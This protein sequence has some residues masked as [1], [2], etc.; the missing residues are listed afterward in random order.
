MPHEFTHR[1]WQSFRGVGGRHRPPF[2][3]SLHDAS[4]FR[5]ASRPPGSFLGHQTDEALVVTWPSTPDGRLRSP[6]P[7]DGASLRSRATDRNDQ[8]LGGTVLLQKRRT[9]TMTIDRECA[10]NLF[11]GFLSTSFSIEKLGGAVADH[12]G[13]TGFWGTAA[14]INEYV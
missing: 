8:N 5:Q 14:P 10:L 13:L 3:P 4:I 2:T 12:A 9:S 11:V 7:R 6:K 1:D